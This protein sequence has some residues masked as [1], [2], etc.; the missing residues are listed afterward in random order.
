MTTTLLDLL[1]L[2]GQKDLTDKTRITS[3]DLV[4]LFSTALEGSMWCGVHNDDEIWDDES[5]AGD[6]LEEH[7]ANILMAGHPLRFYDVEGTDGPWE[8]TMDMLD[9]GA[10]KFI[11]DYPALVRQVITDDGFDG[12]TGDA[13]FQCILLGDIVYG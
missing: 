11:T 6:C 5:L 4:D 10:T 1:I 2:V 3:G 12:E 8:L 7:M 9:K 13:L